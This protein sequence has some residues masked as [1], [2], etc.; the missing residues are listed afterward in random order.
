MLLR[1]RAT[2][3]DNQKKEGQIIPLGN[4]SSLVKPLASVGKALATDGMQLIFSLAIVW[5]H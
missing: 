1:F 5:G 4:G 2:S 3:G